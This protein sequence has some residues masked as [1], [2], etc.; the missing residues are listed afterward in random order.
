MKK[1]DRK[2]RRHVLVC[3]NQR[4]SGL[5]CCQDVGGQEVFDTLKA[6]TLNTKQYDIW[7]TKTGCMGWCAAQGSTVIVYPEGTIY[8]GVTPDDVEELITRHLSE[9]EEERNH[10]DS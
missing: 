1:V 4:E 2:P 9:S 5:P 6:Y 8:K 3:V 7:I 10:K